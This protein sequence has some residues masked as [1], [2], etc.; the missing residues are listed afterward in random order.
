[1]RDIGFDADIKE[2]RIWLR[3]RVIE[4][5]QETYEGW[6]TRRQWD[7]RAKEPSVTVG[8]VAGDLLQAW[9]PDEL[10][11]FKTAAGRRR[12][13]REVRSALESARKKGILD[14]S[15]GIGLH[16]REARCYEPKS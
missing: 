5:V 7:S 8:L 11:P 1:M 6:R 10:N 12:F 16:G 13:V 2:C 4:I 3:S 14:S 9:L 15:I